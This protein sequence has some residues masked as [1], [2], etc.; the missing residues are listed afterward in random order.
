MPKLFCGIQV[1]PLFVLLNTPLAV[2]RYIVEGVEGS[3]TIEIIERDS[4]NGSPVATAVGGLEETELA[5]IN[6]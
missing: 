6:D 3:N 5:D 2:P 4:T 1:L